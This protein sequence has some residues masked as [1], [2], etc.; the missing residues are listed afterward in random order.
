[1][2]GVAGLGPTADEIFENA[3]CGLLVTT[4]QGRI[5]RANGTFCRWIGMQPDEIVGHKRFADLLTMGGR[6]FHQTHWSP[7]LQLQGSVAEVK[8]ELRHRDGRK[9]R[10]LVNAARRPHGD[11]DYD[12]LACMVMDERH[13]YEQ[14]LLDERQKAELALKVASSSEMALQIADR[15]KDEFLATLAH[16]IRNPL[17]TLRAVADVLER[18]EFSDPQITW[19]RGVIGRQVGHIT[20]LMDDLLEVSRIGEGKLQMRDVAVDVVS[21]ARQALESSQSLIKASAHTVNVDI[22]SAPLL[23]QGDPTRLSQVMQNLL[24]NAA[25][26]TPHGGVIWFSVKQQEDDAVIMVRDNGIG[27][28]EQ[29][30]LSIFGLYAQLPQGESRSQGGLGIGLALVKAL[31]ERHGGTVSAQSEGKGLG[32]EFA[33]H[34]PVIGVDV[35]SPD[36]APDRRQQETPSPRRTQRILIVDDNPDAA[37]S[38]SMLLEMDGHETRTVGDGKDALRI[39]VEFRADTVILDIGLPGMNG[40]EVAQVL[41]QREKTRETKLIA[42][43]GRAQQQDRDMA[44]DAGFDLHL[45]KPVDYSVLCQFLAA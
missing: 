31:V 23:V 40:Y 18:K 38:L 43:T 8:L 34:I 6:I 19:A 35:G 29:D 11:V 15:H 25:K 5:V 7:L 32:S 26:Y 45:S 39:Q 12:H 27:I 14:E 21:V 24:S 33:V 17:A 13:S 42:L 36:F 20:H 44:L 2:T 10:M 28:G 30:L 37:A 9:I 16:E 1:M 41:R 22:Q 4:T 3:G